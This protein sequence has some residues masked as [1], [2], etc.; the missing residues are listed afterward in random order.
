MFIN[1]S[2]PFFSNIQAF[3]KLNESSG[4]RS[5]NI[6]TF[7]LAVTGTVGSS[8]GLF[9]SNA[10]F[11]NAANN[12]L[13][14]ARSGGI[15]QVGSH[16]FVLMFKADASH[17]GNIRLFD[18]D[19]ARYQV[20]YNGSS[21]FVQFYVDGAA[22]GSVLQYS[23]NVPP[24]TAVARD[25][26]HMVAV[27]VDV[28]ASEVRFYRGGGANS[29]VSSHVTGNMSG[30]NLRVGYAGSGSPS[31]SIENLMYLNTAL[32][33]A[34]LIS[35][36][37]SGNFYD[38][39]VVGMTPSPATI[40]AGTANQTVVL[41][42]TATSWNPASPPTFTLSGVSGVSLVNRVVNSPTDATLTI[43]TGSSLGTVTVTDPT[44]SITTTFEVIASTYSSGVELTIP[45]NYRF[46]SQGSHYQN[47]MTHAS[48]TESTG[49]GYIYVPTSFV[50]SQLTPSKN[51]VVAFWNSATKPITLEVAI[52]R[53]VTDTPTQI[54][55]NGGSNS[56]VIQ[57][58]QYATSD[59][60][61]VGTIQADGYIPFRYYMSWT[62]AGI[63][64]QY[65]DSQSTRRTIG[66]G[67]DKGFV[68]G[69]G[70]RLLE[71]GL[72]NSFTSLSDGSNYLFA[73]FAMFTEG[74]TGAN[75]LV[76]GD[77]ISTTV[78][79]QT[80]G[81][82][83][84][85][86]PQVPYLN[87]SLGGDA[88]NNYMSAPGV[89]ATTGATPLNKS[90][91]AIIRYFSNIINAYG[92]N[93]M[94]QSSDT[95][96]I[97]RYTTNV[98]GFSARTDIPGNFYQWTLS[99]KTSLISG[100]WAD[101]TPAQQTALP[102]SDNAVVVNQTLRSN[103]SAYGI[104]AIIEVAGATRA[105]GIDD[106]KWKIPNYTG[107]GT[108]PANPAFANAVAAVAVSPSAL[109]T[110]AQIIGGGE[111]GAT[112]NGG[113]GGK[114][115]RTA[116]TTVQVM[117]KP[118][119]KERSNFYP[120]TLESGDDVTFNPGYRVKSVVVRMDKGDQPT[121]SVDKETNT[122]TITATDDCTGVLSVKY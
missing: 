70:N 120:F 26:W 122:I 21:N 39:A 40:P 109:K 88:L 34:Q 32:T 115:R 10:A 96:N 78:G 50:G 16:T 45:T 57:P 23:S 13:S 92:H 98:A 24:G 47:G 91:L 44:N 86:Y 55:F 59:P 2:S 83:H 35:L 90:R 107:D 14:I 4:S 114:P 18:T 66:S 43:T 9:S 89:F 121:V 69:G 80:G 49:K 95:A 20:E 6:G 15:N 116:K 82:I 48:G 64:L 33:D 62:G 52:Q 56:V 22:A 58:G 105:P 3:W 7:P 25:I 71:V 12:Y 103:P 36:Y 93:D 68:I 101:A 17:S 30:G 94:Y 31:V 75:V 5:S 110:W 29:V 74:Y 76:F 108:H 113:V 19:T 46:V 54:T 117:T 111:V 63:S 37:D 72:E 60:F 84:T 85:A 77:S 8:T 65:P 38:L 42:G 11:F 100:T 67:L 53:V 61:A 104:D 118:V 112:V 106:L 81:W 79:I 28:A 87:T 97:S 51:V 41:T 99:P 102:G 119:V 73:P 1:S 27:V